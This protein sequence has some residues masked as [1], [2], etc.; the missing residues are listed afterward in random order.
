MQ[1]KAQCG[2]TGNINIT[3][4]RLSYYPMSNDYVNII[5]DAVKDV[6]SSK[7]YSK[8]D[9]FSTMYRGSQS[10]VV[11]T[12]KQLFTNAYHKD[13]HSVCELTFSKGC[14]GD[15][16]ADVIIQENELDNLDVK[17]DDSFLVHAKY[18]FYVFGDNDYMKEIMYIVELA[19]K[20]NLKPTSDHYVTLLTGSAKDM[21][22]YFNEVLSYSF[23]NLNHYVLEATLS[24]N[25][26]SLKGETL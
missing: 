18:S 14:P 10:Y 13:I 3:G 8:T 9:L 7:V 25:S 26:P 12:A 24:V 2:C 4:C 23:K 17:T 15:V 5:L 20:Y 11:H 6:D 1:N 19:N 22:D 21:F 16:D